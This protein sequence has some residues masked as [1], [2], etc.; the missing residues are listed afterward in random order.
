M[1]KPPEGGQIQE[2]PHL[3]GLGFAQMA[4]RGL[5]QKPTDFLCFW[6]VRSP[7]NSLLIRLHN[8]RTAGRH[9]FVANASNRIAD[10]LETVVGDKADV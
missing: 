2:S 7:L 6:A 4:Q 1:K 8:R 9:E 3:A 5:A 10:D